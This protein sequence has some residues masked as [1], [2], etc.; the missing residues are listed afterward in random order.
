MVIGGTPITGGE[1]KVWGPAIG[2][3]IYIILQN[4]FVLMNV[5]CFWQLVVSGFLIMVT[6][7]LDNCQRR[8]HAL[9]RIP[10]EL[11]SV[12]PEVGPRLSSPIPG[13]EAM[14]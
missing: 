10:K 3:L 8:L 6:V 11:D 4:G 1:G 14:L 2:A 12:S 9:T 13:G 7:S 5:A